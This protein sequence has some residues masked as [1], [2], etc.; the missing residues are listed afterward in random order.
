MNQT[1][2]G[3]KNHQERFESK[4]YHDHWCLADATNLSLLLGC[5]PSKHQIIALFERV[6][7]VFVFHKHRHCPS[8]INSIQIP[9][10]F[11]PSRLLSHIVLND[12]HGCRLSP[13]FW[14][15]PLLWMTTL[16]D[17]TNHQVLQ[18]SATKGIFLIESFSSCPTWSEI[19]KHA[20]LF[21]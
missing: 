7:S 10:K 15:S 1:S 19:S 16:V 12:N 17:L 6:V 14:W 13:K 5:R 18:H 21:A 9:D 3:G 2:A 4:V 20:G 8:A 11:R